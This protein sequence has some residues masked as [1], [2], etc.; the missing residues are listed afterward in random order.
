M[1]GSKG[2]PYTLESFKHRH[3]L[4]PQTANGRDLLPSSKYDPQMP[5]KSS[6]RASSGLAALHLTC[7]PACVLLM[8]LQSA[9]EVT[10]IHLG[11]NTHSSTQLIPQT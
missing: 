7:H 8:R 10:C 5:S 6:Q 2:M 9:V 11:C 3:E 1:A 4:L